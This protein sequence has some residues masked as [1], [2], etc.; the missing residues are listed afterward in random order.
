MRLS[1][2]LDGFESSG[3]RKALQSESG[4]KNGA[5]PLTEARP[6]AEI[7]QEVLAAYDQ[8]AANLFRYALA[9]DTL[10]CHG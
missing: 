8:F 10:R 2:A 9:L 1:H 3:L 6:P 7:E 5:R 4:L